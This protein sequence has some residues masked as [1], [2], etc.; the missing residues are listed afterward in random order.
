MALE[1]SV[2]AAWMR[3]WRLPQPNCT[4]LPLGEPP[5]RNAACRGGV[6]DGA[7]A[8]SE[9]HVFVEVAQACERC[10]EIEGRVRQG[11]AAKRLRQFQRESPD[12]L[13]VYSTTTW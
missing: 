3:R 6:N 4:R 2:S 10:G 1:R 8:G 9:T 11:R 5:V 12:R 7:G 13:L